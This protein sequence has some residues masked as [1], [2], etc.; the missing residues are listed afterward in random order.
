MIRVFL[1]LVLVAA[2]C[3][4]SLGGESRVEL[5]GIATPSMYRLTVDEA[6][7]WQTPIDAGTFE[8]FTIEKPTWG[9]FDWRP[10]VTGNWFAKIDLTPYPQPWGIEWLGQDVFRF[11]TGAGEHTEILPMYAVPEPSSLSVAL[12]VVFSIGTWVVFSALQASIS[13]KWSADDEAKARSFGQSSACGN[14]A[15]A[16]PDT[17]AQQQRTNRVDSIGHRER[18][19]D[20]LDPMRCVAVDDDGGGAVAGRGGVGGGSPGTTGDPLPRSVERSWN[21]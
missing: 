4:S 11:Q 13:R 16:G 19:L 14:V 9:E 21:N 15:T 6:S 7:P 3:T 8:Y 5:R 12:V 17:G 18:S 10:D 20:R 2:A 1:S